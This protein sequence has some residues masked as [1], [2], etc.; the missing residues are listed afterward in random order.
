M[1]ENRRTPRNT[2]RRIRSVHRSPMTSRVRWIE[3]PGGEE[4]A[5]TAGERRGVGFDSQP[6][7]AGAQLL[8]NTWVACQP[9]SSL[10]Q[11][12]IPIDTKDALV[13]LR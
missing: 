11:K 13:M 2:S 8:W 6:T 5:V 1:R 3:H 10:C 4:A 9:P 12:P 7:P